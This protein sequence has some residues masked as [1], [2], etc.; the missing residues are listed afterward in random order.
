MR[1]GTDYKL[2]LIHIY[3]DAREFY[4]LD[5]L[6]S[7]AEKVEFLTNMQKDK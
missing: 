3:K 1:C 7:D 4:N 5:K 2:S 6:W